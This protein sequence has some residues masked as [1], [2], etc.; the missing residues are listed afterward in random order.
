MCCFHPQ[1]WRMSKAKNQ[2]VASRAKCVCHLQHVDLLLKMEAICAS[3]MLSEWN[4]Q[5]YT[6]EDRAVLIGYYLLIKWWTYTVCWL[7]LWDS[8]IALQMGTKGIWNVSSRVHF[9]IDHWPK[10]GSTQALTI[11]STWV[12]NSIFQECCLCI[13]YFFAWVIF[14]LWYSCMFLGLC[15]NNYNFLFSSSFHMCHLF[16]D[17]LIQI[18]ASMTKYHIHVFMLLAYKL[19]IFS[20]RWPNDVSSLEVY[21]NQNAWKFCCCNKAK[22]Q[23]IKCL[24]KGC[25]RVLV[26]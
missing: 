13:Q 6:S 8:H 18:T 4:T 15:F 21:L 12:K 22:E 11:F 5:R 25:E 19:H 2:Q 23:Q 20:Q 14:L 9:Y 3:E 26:P 17:T 7:G 24:E 10:M 16:L 1:G